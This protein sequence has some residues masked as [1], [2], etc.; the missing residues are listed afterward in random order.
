MAKSETDIAALFS[1]MPL[2]E[3]TT[4]LA[5]LT[6]LHNTAKAAKRAELMAELQELGGAPEPV[7][8]TRGPNKPREPL[9]EGDARLT[10]KPMYRAPDGYEWSGRGAIPKAFKALGVV[11]KAGM[12]QYRITTGD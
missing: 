1:A 4:L 2:A 6:T 7:K 8:R 9:P 12:S 3:Q 10:V 11:D 5:E